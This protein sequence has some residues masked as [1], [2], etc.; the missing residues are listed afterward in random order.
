MEEDR[1]TQ[2]LSQV[3]PR[4]T[5]ALVCFRTSRVFLLPAPPRGAPVDRLSAALDLLSRAAFVLPDGGM[6]DGRP[7][8]YGPGP[9]AGG[10]GGG[11]DLSQPHGGGGDRE[12]RPHHRPG[13]PPPLRGAPRRAGGPGRLHGGPRR[14]HPVRDI[15][16]LLPPGA[17]APLHPGG[18]G[19]RH[20]P[21]G[22]G[23][24]RPQPPGGGQGHRPAA[25][26]GAGG[27]RGGTGGGVPPAQPV[28]SSTTS[29]P[30]GPTW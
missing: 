29:A 12:G 8:L 28:F 2:D 10:A 15:G 25:G 6:R 5:A 7:R 24:H 22:G 11:V 1:K 26:A 30:G 14:V 23:H 17:A 27:D 9:G 13:L 19:R 3:P 16:A 4:H 18:A 21:G 20:P